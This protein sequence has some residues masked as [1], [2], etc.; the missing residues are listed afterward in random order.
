M[1]SEPPNQLLSLA[2]IGLCTPDSGGQGIRIGPP[3]PAAAYPADCRARTAKGRCPKTGPAA[4]EDSKLS[5]NYLKSY[6]Y[7]KGRFSGG[8]VDGPSSENWNGSSSLFACA[9]FG[10]LCNAIADRRQAARRPGAS[11]RLRRLASTGR[12]TSDQ[13][14]WSTVRA[15]DLPPTHKLPQLAAFS[16]R[17]PC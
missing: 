4:E 1:P 6:S 13:P 5:T 15:I 7:S 2:E 11:T 3:T 8:P 12:R 17:D 9:E 16:L 14:T 10:R